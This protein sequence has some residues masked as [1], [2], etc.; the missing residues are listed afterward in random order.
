MIFDN[1]KLLAKAE[2]CTLTT[3]CRPNSKNAK[4]RLKFDQIRPLK[5]AKKG[6]D[7][8]VDRSVELRLGFC[9]QQKSYPRVGRGL[10]VQAEGCKSFLNS[11]PIDACALNPTPIWDDL[12]YTPRKSTP[13]W[14]DG[15]GGRGGWLVQTGRIPDKTDR[16]HI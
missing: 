3:L 14:D 2:H 11:T 6:F 12:G 4:R 8:S 13:I 16:A 5:N 15:G 10:R 7:R 9:Y 1:L